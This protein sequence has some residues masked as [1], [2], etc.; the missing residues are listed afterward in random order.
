MFVLRDYDFESDEEH[1]KKS[2][3]ADLATIWNDIYKPAEFKDSKAEDFFAVD[4]C[5]MPHKK[6]QGE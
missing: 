1:V 3:H 4:F 5:L 2:I 6:W